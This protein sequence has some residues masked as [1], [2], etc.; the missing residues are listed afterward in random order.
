MDKSAYGEANY[1]NIQ[2][3]HTPRTH[4]DTSEMRETGKAGSV[5][6]NSSALVGRLLKHNSSALVGRLL[7][8]NNSAL[9][10]RLLKHNN[11][12]LVGRLS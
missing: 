7:K 8:H 11:S 1:R 6:R 10:G 9:V 4:M 12:A 5:E 3:F 2:N